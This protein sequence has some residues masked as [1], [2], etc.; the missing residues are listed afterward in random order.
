[1]EE[2]SEGARQEV[3]KEE[4]TDVNKTDTEIFETDIVRIC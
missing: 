2:E 4:K 1:M 3:I